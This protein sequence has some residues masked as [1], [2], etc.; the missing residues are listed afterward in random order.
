MERR[1][2]YELIYLICLHECCSRIVVSVLYVLGHIYIHT[3]IS[4]PG[5]DCPFPFQTEGCP[6]YL[7]PSQIGSQTRVPSSFA[8]SSLA[9]STYTFLLFTFCPLPLLFLY[10]LL[11][12]HTLLLFIQPLFFVPEI[13]QVTEVYSKD[14]AKG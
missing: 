14:A 8:P 7:V 12:H 11:I 4:D 1:Y 9:K 3:C 2:K 6:R 10:P 5:C 13:D